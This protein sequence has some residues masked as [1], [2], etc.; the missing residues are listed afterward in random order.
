MT[1]FAYSA[2]ETNSGIVYDFGTF[3]NN[4]LNVIGTSPNS[5]H[6]KLMTSS[7]GLC[8]FVRICA[9]VSLPRAVIQETA[10]QI[11]KEAGLEVE[12]TE[13]MSDKNQ[14]ETKS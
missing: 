10:R 11:L 14:L 13:P 7:P 6:V 12:N 3:E 1:T 8:E 2:R 9:Y 5:Y 4:K